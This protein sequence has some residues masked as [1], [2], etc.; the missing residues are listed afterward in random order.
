MCRNA[1][2][3]Q[4]KYHRKGTHILEDHVSVD[5]LDNDRFQFQKP[6]FL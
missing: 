4:T 5:N 6:G 1:L 3:Q 2:D